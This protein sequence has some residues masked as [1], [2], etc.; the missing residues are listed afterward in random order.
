[1]NILVVDD[2]PVFLSGMVTLL[3]RLKKGYNV[4]DAC[5]GQMAYDFMRTEKY[6]VV[7]MDLDMPV[8]NGFE[9]LKK[10]KDT[11]PK[12]RPKIIVMSVNE[13]EAS[14]AACYKLNA[15][16]YIPKSTSREEL[17]RLFES[18]S[19]DDLYFPKG[20]FA[21]LLN[22]IFLGTQ[23]KKLRELKPSAQLSALECKFLVLTAYE[24]PNKAIANKLGSTE[25]TIKSMKYKLYKKIKCKNMVGAT[26][27]GL[28]N[29]L[30][31]IRDLNDNNQIHFLLDKFNSI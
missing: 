14:I 5:N 27:Y 29:Q 8:M 12:P 19:N 10:I 26:L 17:I 22:N 1:M 31:T 30:F 23:N 25:A 15:D 16:G 21:K 18:L 4:E 28:K 3:K 9:L 20:M 13:D 11:L 6:D 24:Y 2:H 7:F